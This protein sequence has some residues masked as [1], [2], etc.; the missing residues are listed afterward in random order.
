VRAD[1][2]PLTHAYLEAM[3]RHVGVEVSVNTSLNVG[4]PIAQTP[5]QALTTLG[6][7][8]AMD[9]LVLVAATGEAWIAWTPTGEERVR[10]AIG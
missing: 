2:D 3:G 6:R 8:A 1:T 7:A 5:T 9:A 10:A 4:A